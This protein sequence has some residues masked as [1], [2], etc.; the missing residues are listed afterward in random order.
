[1][2]QNRTSP[3][4]FA[5]ATI[6]LILGIWP[7]ASEAATITVTGT[8][9][10]VAVNGI[11]TLREAI[12][13]VNAGANVNAD[14][15]AVGA[16]GTN[17]TINF[18]IPGAGVHT[19]QPTSPFVVTKRVLI[20]GYSQSGASVNALAVGNN[21]V[22][23]IEIDGINAGNLTGGLLDIGGGASTV[24]GLVINRA[25][26]GGGVG[27]RLVTNPGNTVSGN[28][29]GTNPAGTIGRSNGCQGV[30]VDS[31]GNTIGGLS[32][33]D[34]NLVSAT[35]GCGGNIA[36]SSSNNVIQ[37]NYIGT[38]AAGTAGLGGAGGVVIGNGS[39]GNLVG[40]TTTAARNVVSGHDGRGVVLFDS[41]TSGN[42]IAGNF[43]GTDSS[44]TLPLPNASYGVE[45]TSETHDNTVGGTG[46][47]AGNTIAFNPIAGVVV[48]GS[49]FSAGSGNA[50]L[51]NSIFSNGG[52][53]I[54][55]AEPGVEANDACDGDTG[56][57]NRQNFP[58]I[59]SATAGASSITVEG[60]L[61]S[62][63][64]TGPY[65]IEIFAND[66]C[67]VSGFGEGKTFL[68]STTTST[69]PT[70]NG[71]FNVTLPV[72][73][74]PTARLTATATDPNGS[75]SEFSACVGVQTT[76]FTVSPCRIADTRDAPGP[77]GGP[78]LAANTVRT[79]P[80]AG[81]CGIPSSARA[82]AIN[83][84]VFQ[85][86][87]AG[88]LRVY[89]SGGT[90]PLASAINFRTGIVRANNAVVPL[91]AAGQISVQ[92]DMPSGSTHFFFDV[93]GY[94]Q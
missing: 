93:Y 78:A 57:N 15:V 70:C 62:T 19:I 54:D 83:L 49:P 30:G 38:N 55:V 64:S 76:F 2:T 1:M 58:V 91:G 72:L 53:G 31:S 32:P 66:S 92:C 23:L 26:G 28:F 63:A 71:N 79:F 9:D 75:T 7:A 24:K 82:V 22:L 74:A 33:A 6:V 21:A 86:S 47:G 8:G 67:D 88:D 60:T 18:A 4:L 51:G 80:V 73:V 39:T 87:N 20:N 41:S 11:V 40:G 43:I 68:G 10:T 45:I 25:Q 46:A 14:V 5:L 35:E 81:L 52:L 27:L 17:D 56:A 36:V 13:S 37:N 29:I 65:R 59:T 84:A 90:A 61:N 50:V 34:R 85:P 48:A 89:P 16:Y 94:F 42:V 12:D 77:S 69:D 44:G 3:F